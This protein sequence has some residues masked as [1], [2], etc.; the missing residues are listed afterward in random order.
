M[1][2]EWIDKEYDMNEILSRLE[3][4]KENYPTE[5]PG[6]H[7]GEPLLMKTED[8]ESLMEWIWENYGEGGHIQTNGTMIGDQHIE[9]FKEYEWTV[10]VSCDGPGELNDHRVAYEG[11]EDVTRNHTEKTNKNIRRLAEEGIN[12]GVI[13]VLQEGNAGTDEKLERLLEW[14]TDLA[15]YGVSGHFNPAIPYED[16]QEDISLSSERLKEVYLRVWEWVKADPD[17]QWDPM[18][19]YIDNLLGL[20]LQNCVNNKCD[21]FNAGSA[22][23]ITGEGETT[24]CGKTWSAA[25]DGGVFLQGE[26]TGNEFNDTEERYEMLRKTPGPAFVDDSTPDMGGCEGCK[27]WN[28]CQGGCPS[29]GMGFDYRNRTVWCEAKYALYQEVEN[30]IRSVMPNIT[31]ITDYPWNANLSDAVHEDIDI[32]PFAAMDP[33]VEGKSSAVKGFEHP[34]RNPID[35]VPDDIFEGM[36]NQDWIKY[37]KSRGVDEKD[38]EVTNGGVHTDSRSGSQQ[39]DARGWGKVEEGD[40]ARASP[41]ADEIEDSEFLSDEEI[42][43]LNQVNPRMQEDLKE[44]FLSNELS[45]EHMEVTE[46]GYHADSQPG[47]GQRQPDRQHHNRSESPDQHQRGNRERKKVDSLDDVPPEFRDRL[48]RKMR[49]NGWQ[50]EDIRVSNDGFHVDSSIR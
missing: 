3:E 21:V 13:V 48:K 10:G 9:L 37:H 41:D 8:M 23:I 11:G 30:Y 26:S 18:E 46:G 43:V 22:K 5:T 42:R 24:G 15:E 17:H 14:M 4:Y 38:I 28:V 40:D 2:E 44:K 47:M 16:I 45:A 20:D 32:Q 27:F 6:F 34:Q 25:G 36:S 35:R 19:Q 33:S 12:V 1:K 49:E 31:L 39:R 7:G 50:L 29:S